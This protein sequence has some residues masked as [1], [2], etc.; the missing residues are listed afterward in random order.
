MI[1]RNSDKL[2]INR[3][4][5]EFTLSVIALVEKQEIELPV[6]YANISDVEKEEIR[7]RFGSD[8]I[9]LENVIK[10]W[11][12]RLLAAS[13]KGKLT[14]LKLIAVN[15]ESVFGWENVKIYKTK[16]SNGKVINILRSANVVGRK[17]NR[18]KGVRIAM[19]RTMLLQQDGKFHN[20]VVKDLSYCGMGFVQQGICTVKS[21]EP[22]TLFLTENKADG[23]KV[24]GKFIGK[25][26]NTRE[27]EDGYTFCGCILSSEHA[28]FLQRF[29]ARK[30]M[31][32]LRGRR[33]C[34]ES[35]QI[36]PTDSLKEQYIDSL[37][38]SLNS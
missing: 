6:E 26:V 29:I 5:K 31:E 38:D 1:D 18:R 28:V 11:E 30:Q 9:P 25:V 13:F 12:E 24:V 23:E 3:V 8:V 14:S 33:F 10:V 37:L 17:I 20:I 36:V 35:N 4:T 34:F 15:T 7:S 21:G 16:L 22:F 32:E 19:N 2:L 27:L